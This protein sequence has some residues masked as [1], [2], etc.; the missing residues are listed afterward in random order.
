MLTRHTPSAFKTTG[1]PQK[2]AADPASA[3]STALLSI[4]GPASLAHREAGM[5]SSVAELPKAC[6]SFRHELIYGTHLCSADLIRVS[7]LQK[8]GLSLTT[9]LF[10]LLADSYRTLTLF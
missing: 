3:T 1:V 8:R 7:V 10:F 6:K 9:R 5:E 4:V 2:A